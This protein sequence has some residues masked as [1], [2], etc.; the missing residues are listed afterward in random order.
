MTPIYFPFT[1][2]DAPT[3]QAMTAVFPKIAVYHPL[4]Q[5]L[6]S[7]LQSFEQAGKVDIR[8]PVTEDSKLLEM[9]VVDY[10]NWARLHQGNDL[11]FLKSRQTDAPFI[12]H[13]SS[14]IQSEILNYQEASPASSR[15]PVFNARL[16]LEIAAAYDAQQTE[17]NRDLSIVTNMEKRFMAALGDSSETDTPVSLGNL[18]LIQDDPGDFM[19]TERIQAWSTLFLQDNRYRTAEGLWITS[20]ASVI[21][22]IQDENDMA[23]VLEITCIPIQKTVDDN[24]TRF[25]QESILAYLT[26]LQTTAWPSAVKT[27]EPPSS[28]YAWEN[29][30]S[31]KGFIIPNVSPDGFFQQMATCQ[32]TGSLMNTFDSKQPLHTIIVYVDAL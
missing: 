32:K 5:K 28:E 11:A 12:D 31:M 16:F 20:S 1:W 9:M 21:D 23:P 30:V 3:V 17:L 24:S 19:L 6:P 7:W 4:V 13:L 10:Q 25:W 18:P 29:A 2:T 15:N 14:R 8:V 26:Q 22:W 27:F